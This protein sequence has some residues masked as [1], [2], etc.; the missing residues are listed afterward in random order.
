LSRKLISAFL[1]VGEDCHV[2][3]PTLIAVRQLPA[4]AVRVSTEAEA[5][6][7]PAAVALVVTQ[8]EERAWPEAPVSP[9]AEGEVEELAAARADIE[10]APNDSVVAPAEAVV[11]VRDGTAAVAVVEP[12]ESPAAQAELVVEQACCPAV[13]VWSAAALVGAD[14]V[15]HPDDCLGGQVSSEVG[16]VVV[17]RVAH[18][19]GL[20]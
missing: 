13:Q 3:E 11:A 12:D 9:Q 14:L 6:I 1:F 15:E 20:A 19:V 5:S 18:P 16:L 8:A 17:G 7:E 2:R 10:A 4:A